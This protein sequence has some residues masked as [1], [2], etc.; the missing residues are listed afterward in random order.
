MHNTQL[1]QVTKQPVKTVF[2]MKN[3]LD[4]IP[5]H[6]KN[7]GRNFSNDYLSQTFRRI[8][9]EETMKKLFYDGSVRNTTDFIK[10]FRDGEKEI[11]FVEYDGKEVGFFWLNKFRHKSAFINY[12]F[13]KEFWGEKALEISKQTID[14]AF[15]RKNSEGEHLTD[16][17]LGLTP[18]NNKLAIQ[19]LLKNGMTVSGKVPGFL[20]DAI[21]EITVD[22]IFSYLQRDNKSTIK[23]P[24][25][26][27]IN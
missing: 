1:Q 13:Y 3:G 12:C 18:A 9:R 19:F 24:T 4:I 6:E 25:F 22:G 20:Y 17:L 23:F 11:F 14:F 26:L 5:F 27:F 16:V 8:V 2:Q 21:E 7:G 10:F 15:S